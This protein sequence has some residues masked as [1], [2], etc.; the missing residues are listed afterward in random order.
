M[1]R[2]QRIFFLPLSMTLLSASAAFAYEVP[3]SVSPG[4]VEKR[5][6]QPLTAPE[7]PNLQL[8]VQQEQELSK[9]A[10]EKL[11]KQKFVLK[12]VVI[13]GAT[14]YKPSDLAFAYKDKV[15]NTI[16]L[17]DAQD[18]A[19]AITKRYHEDGYILSQ[20]VVPPQDV[21]NGIL[22]V[23]VVE[24]FVGSVII[25]DDSISSGERRVIESYADNIK[26]MHPVRTQD[27]EHYLLLIDDLPG[28]TVNG[29]LR[30]LP[31]E[32]GAAE[33]VLVLKHKSIDASY[34]MDN[35]GSRYIGPWQH[36][37]AFAINSGLGLYDRTQG[38][39]FF[40]NLDARQMLGGEF[41]HEEPIGNQ[42]TK[43]GFLMSHIHTR[44]GDTLKALDI[45]GNSDLFE[46]KVTHPFVRLR[47]ENLIAR[48][49]LDYHD[50]T[51]DIFN[52]T[53]FSKDRLRVFRAG[54]TYNLLDK[55]KG[56]NLIDVSMS[57][58]LNIFAATS[59]GT[60][61]SNA[62]GD[63][64]F[65][66]FNFDL[67]RVQSLPENF[68]F[69]VGGTGQ[70]S[71]DPL[72]ADE[73]FGLGGSEYARAFDSSDVLGDSGL[74][75]KV[76]LRYTGAVNE[77]YFDAYQPYA[78]YDIGRVWVRD[79]AIGA[80]DKTVRSSTGAGIRLTMT[81]NFSANF[82]AAVPLIK[83]SQ[84]QTDYRHNPRFFMALT[85]RY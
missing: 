41:L 64:S 84:D 33:L 54:A 10:R 80:S 43:L 45:N 28:S 5:F 83:I 66:K 76:E 78:F 42:G 13:E 15:G 44:P 67:S 18:I 79:G 29:I 2:L 70:Y 71:L 22:K 21:T 16:S 81:K 19:S 11:E 65:T 58:G 61:R 4:Q 36:T 73:Q 26:A 6:E 52:D 85:A 17:L 46:L 74:A 75:G 53:G 51:T 56:N 27:L 34:T 57:Q 12:E 30:P 49:V 60:N 20:A 62:F 69:L 48:A 63:S 23:R 14:I 32:F 59:G 55:M 3:N 1:R 9:E 24:G 39:L 31:T 40:S 35:R 37:A 68:S 25:Q 82:E 38:R 72:L 47:R 77:P 7:S 50:T 8:P